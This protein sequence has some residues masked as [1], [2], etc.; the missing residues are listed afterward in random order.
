MNTWQDQ[1]VPANKDDKREALDYVKNLAAGSNTNT[2]GAL[3]ESLD[4]DDQLEA[5]HRLTDGEPTSGAIVKQSEILTDVLRRNQN[6]NITINTV[7]LAVDPN[8]QRFL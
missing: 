4:F 8:M 1:L 6:R 5:I 2:Y 3:R 7:A